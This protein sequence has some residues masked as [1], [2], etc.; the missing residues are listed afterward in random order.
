M[1]NVCESE[2]SNLDALKKLKEIQS[3]KFYRHLF[4]L[5]LDPSRKLRGGCSLDLDIV[6]FVSAA[7]WDNGAHNP[8]LEINFLT[9]IIKISDDLSPAWLAALDD[10]LLEALTQFMN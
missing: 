2:S 8:M 9:R 6:Q 1:Q 7:K 5:T 3:E 10:R 4:L